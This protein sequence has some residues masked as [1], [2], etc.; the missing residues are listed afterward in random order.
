MLSSTAQR[1]IKKSYNQKIS[2][3]KCVCMHQK[4]LNTLGVKMNNRI[5]G[6]ILIVVGIALTLWGYDVYESAGSQISRVFSGDTPMEAWLGLVGCAICIIV[7]VR[8]VK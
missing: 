7:G 6:I 5:I 8:K 4:S 2:T 1:S 3:D